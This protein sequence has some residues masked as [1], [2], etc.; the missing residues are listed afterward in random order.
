MIEFHKSETKEIGGLTGCQSKWSDW[1][2]QRTRSLT[3]G[4]HVWLFKFN[5][6]HMKHENRQNGQ[7]LCIFESMYVVLSF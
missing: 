7:H 3:V 2:D 5:K 4:L 1:N 6:K